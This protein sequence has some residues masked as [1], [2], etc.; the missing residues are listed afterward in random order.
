[1]MKQAF[2]P[3]A[4]FILFVL[5]LLFLR[6]DD[7]YGPAPVLRAYQSFS[8]YTNSKSLPS[9]PALDPGTPE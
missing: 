8:Q 3:V 7:D 4:P 5:V 2:M 9:A 6:T 1:M